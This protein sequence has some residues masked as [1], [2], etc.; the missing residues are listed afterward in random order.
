[1]A[2][3]LPF[4]APGISKLDDRYVP[5]AEV[6]PGILNVSYRESC[7]SESKRQGLQSAQSDRSGSAI[8]KELLIS[9]FNSI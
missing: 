7:P 6:N 2:A 9:T 1:L 3:L 8:F 4:S 5:Q